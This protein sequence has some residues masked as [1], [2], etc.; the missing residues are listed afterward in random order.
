MPSHM[1]TR[2]PPIELPDLAGARVTAPPAREPAR[3]VE[4]YRSTPSEK[5]VV[6]AGTV[7][8]PSSASEA[9]SR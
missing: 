3:P 8:S 6:S 5:P 2:Q 4:A 7:T 1:N 9:S